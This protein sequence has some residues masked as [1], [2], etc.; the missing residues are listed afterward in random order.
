MDTPPTPTTRTSN[1][2]HPSQT[3]EPTTREPP[4]KVTSIQS[5]RISIT[6]S[7]AAAALK[8]RMRRQK[9]TLTRPKD[10]QMTRTI[11]NTRQSTTLVGPTLAPTITSIEIPMEAIQLPPTTPSPR[12]PIVHYP[13]S[14]P[15]HSPLS[16][17]LPPI[18]AED[19]PTPPGYAHQLTP[20]EAPRRR[21]QGTPPNDTAEAG[22]TTP[23]VRGI[24]EADRSDPH[25]GRSNLRT[26]LDKFTPG[27]MPH[28]QDA[29][30]TSIFEYLDLDLISD[31]ENFQRGKLIAIPFDNEAR[32]V[33]MHED[34]KARLMAAIADITK[35]QNVGVATPRA[36]AEALAAKHHPNAFLVFNLTPEQVD[37]LLER[38]IWSSTAITFRAT[39]LGRIC[40]EFLFAIR[41]FH[42]MT[43]EDIEAII[44]RVWTDKLT[45]DFIVTVTNDHP[46]DE[47]EQVYNALANL[48]STLH[49]TRLDIKQPGDLLIPQFNVYAKGREAINLGVWPRVRKF[50]AGRTY[51][52]SMMGTGITS[53]SPYHCGICHSVDHPRGLCPFPEVDGWNGPKRRNEKGKAQPRGRGIGPNTHA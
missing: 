32:T 44:K 8:N 4:T 52:G 24:V 27:P 30:P 22:R 5:A 42:S 19:S 2:P 34:I 6:N 7:P 28:M 11:K 1:L 46:E 36:S 12:V 31:W 51:S 37:T 3:L 17:A 35:S 10:P 48:T 39:P 26:I 16:Y 20:Q 33:N 38:T 9:N 13:S 18:P 21:E 14:E 53:I 41:G 29:H 45:R 15:S 23:S 47:R 40:P 25:V 43:K 50:L 49:L